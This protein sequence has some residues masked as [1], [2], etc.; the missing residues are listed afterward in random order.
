MFTELPFWNRSL[1]SGGAS[2]RLTESESKA[3]PLTLEC[4][5]CGS[6]ESIEHNDLE[7]DV[8]AFNQSVVRYCKECA[9][10]TVWKVSSAQVNDEESANQAASCLAPPIDFR[11]S[12]HIFKRCRK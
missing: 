11:T 3:P 5:R 12:A 1:I 8:F 2:S 6:R 7:V 4:S 9:S 10:S